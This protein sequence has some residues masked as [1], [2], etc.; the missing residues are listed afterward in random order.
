MAARSIFEVYL[1]KYL[2][3]YKKETNR[4]ATAKE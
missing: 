4:K 1:P 2:N 3:K